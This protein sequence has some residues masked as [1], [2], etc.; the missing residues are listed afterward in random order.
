[1]TPEQRS[2]RNCAEDATRTAVEVLQEA[3]KGLAHVSACGLIVACDTTDAQL[4]LIGKYLFAANQRVN[5]VSKWA[6]GDWYNACFERNAANL[7]WLKPGQLQQAR[8]CARTAARFP[9]S[10]PAGAIATP[11]HSNTSWVHTALAGKKTTYAQRQY[12][13]DQFGEEGKGMTADQIREYLG[14]PV[15]VRSPRWTQP[16]HGALTELGKNMGEQEAANLLKAYLHTLSQ[17]DTEARRSL[18]ILLFT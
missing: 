18:I 4:S 1:M 9:R 3:M 13:F 7:R 5:D 14:K 2:V 11:R 12:V 15:L 16:L 6:T 8:N 17:G 10:V